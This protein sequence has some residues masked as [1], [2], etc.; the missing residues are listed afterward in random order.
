MLVECGLT[1]VSVG[2]SEWTFRPSFGRIAALGSPAEIVELFASL[3]GPHA[4]RDAAYVLA[5][6]AD[7]DDV[8]PLVGAWDEI[9]GKLTRVAGTMPDDELVILARHLMTHGIIGKAKP[10][11]GGGEY[12]AEFNAHEYVAAA[13][14][15]LGLSSQDAEALSMTEFQTML[16]MKFP[17]QKK[18]DIPTAEEYEASM[19][20]F[21]ESQRG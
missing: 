2:E 16:E 8:T 4:V 17:Q 9:D 10:G 19:K 1:R 6:L 11:D 3:H 15:H 12:S 5:C 20:A 7:E 18:P 13:R 21:E 14:V